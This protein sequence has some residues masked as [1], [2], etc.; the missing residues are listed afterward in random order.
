MW[1]ALI[2]AAN[3]KDNVRGR[4]MILVV[5]IKIKNGFNHV[6]APSGS[7]WAIVILN[8]LNVLDKIK[9][10]HIGN[11]ID[12]VKIKCLDSLNVY[13]IKPIKLIRIIRVNV[14][15]ISDLVPLIFTV[16]V[17]VSWP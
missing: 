8:D 6:G 16:K 7:K 5:S 10:I 2:L 14:G 3:R 11:P 9:D 15:V 12:I 1:P 4:T 17:R 13:G